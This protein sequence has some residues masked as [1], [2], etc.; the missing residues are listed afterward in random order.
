MD[1]VIIFTFLAQVINLVCDIL[2]PLALLLITFGIISGFLN[3][4]TLRRLT[5]ASFNLNTLGAL[6]LMLAYF[7][8]MLAFLFIFY[9]CNLNY[10]NIC[11]D[12]SKGVA[13]LGLLLLYAGRIISKR[14]GVFYG[15]LHFSTIFIS[16]SI[17]LIF[18]ILI[19][20]KL[21]I[22]DFGSNLSIGTFMRL[23]NQTYH[24]FEDY[25]NILYANNHFVDSFFIISLIGAIILATVREG[26][27][28][29][30]RP[31]S[32]SLLAFSDKFPS[33]LK[34]ITGIHT[35]KDNI[36]KT[37]D[38]MFND[39]IIKIRCATRS[40]VAFDIIKDHIRSQYNNN[41]RKKSGHRNKL[42]YIILKCTKKQAFDDKLEA[43][44]QLPF[45]FTN[46]MKNRNKLFTDFVEEYEKREKSLNDFVARNI[47]K[48]INH[49]LGEAVFI[50]VENRSGT[51]KILL[52][53]KDKGVIN[54]RVGLYSESPYFIEIFLTIFDNALNRENSTPG[55]VSLDPANDSNDHNRTCIEYLDASE[56]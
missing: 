4:V 39:E 54:N 43:I 26:Y 23:M 47:V 50:I 13:I 18:D 56:E 14:Q 40:L 7:I 21:N 55:K 6:D 31:N 17:L 35:K 20:S 28:A 8:G 33:D 19:K 44:C 42:D 46:S 3:D 30:T 27:L 51:Q 15:K 45:S 11:S 12:S 41:L 36:E 22:T 49:Y 53:V 10:N 5:K 2:G 9:Y 52:I 24:I 38:D 16:T 32:K 34:V 37:L 48:S 25:I 29:I 1:G